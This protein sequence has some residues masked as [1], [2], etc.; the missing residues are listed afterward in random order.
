MAYDSQ[1][2]IT[3]LFGGTSNGS[4]PLG[5]TWEYDG[6]TW[7]PASAVFHPSARFSFP[8]VY[9]SA[10]DKILLYGGGYGDG[11]FTILGETWEYNE[12]STAWSAIVQ[13]AR[14]AC[15]H[16]LRPG[17]RLPF[18][19]YRLRSPLPRLLRWRLHRH[20]PGRLPIR[21]QPGPA[22]GLLPG[23]RLNPGRYRYGVARYIEDLYRY[24]SYNRPTFPHSQLYQKGDV[25]FFDW[26]NDGLIDHSAV[27]SQVDFDGRPLALVAAP[28][29]SNGNLTGKAL[30]IAWSSVY[31]D[32]VKDH[33]RLGHPPAPGAHHHHRH[34]AGITHQPGCP[35]S[36]LALAG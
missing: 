31:A 3:V 8:M 16:A 19:L 17:T 2:H 14:P 24:F 25:A 22:A 36:R 27:I 11:R 28:G 7:I 15:R 23:H 30:E 33:A 1:R 13:H 6:T 34:A 32:F 29:Y 20:R 26:D 18:A 35:V 21:R 10:R 9:D 4:D 12:D 5:D